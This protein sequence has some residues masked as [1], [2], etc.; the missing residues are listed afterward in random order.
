MEE[1]GELQSEEEARA[2]VIYMGANKVILT[3]VRMLK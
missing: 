3:G 1:N 2:V